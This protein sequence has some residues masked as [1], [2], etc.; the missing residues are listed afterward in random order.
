[1]TAFLIPLR[2][3]IVLVTMGWLKAEKLQRLKAKKSGGRTPRNIACRLTFRGRFGSFKRT[4][5]PPQWNHRRNAS[6]LPFPSWWRNRSALEKLWAASRGNRW[7][8]AKSGY[9]RR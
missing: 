3:D 8:R 4:K 5:F 6:S 1:M 9:N 7:R 2:I